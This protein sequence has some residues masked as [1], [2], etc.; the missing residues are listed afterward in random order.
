MHHIYSKRSQY[1]APTKAVKTTC[2]L[3]SMDVNDAGFRLRLKM[4]SQK[5]TLHFGN[6]ERK[7]KHLASFKGQHFKKFVFMRLTE[8]A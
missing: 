8:L 2:K 1:N 4:Y 7:Q 3:V 6:T 5:H